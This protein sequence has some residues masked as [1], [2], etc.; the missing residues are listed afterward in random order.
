MKFSIQ[1]HTGVSLTDLL[2]G[3]AWIERGAGHLTTLQ[4]PRDDGTLK[5]AEKENEQSRFDDRAIRYLAFLFRLVEAASW[6]AFT[7]WNNGLHLL[8]TGLLDSE[9]VWFSCLVRDS[10][11]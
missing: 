3:R 10:Y 9:K 2:P 11:T 8:S 6:L 1:D 4:V 7:N 5:A